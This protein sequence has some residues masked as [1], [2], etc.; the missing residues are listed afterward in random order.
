M[1]Y[2]FISGP[3]RTAD[4]EKKVVLGVHGPWQL[5]LLVLRT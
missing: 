4:I 3:S 1:N 2:V 5:F